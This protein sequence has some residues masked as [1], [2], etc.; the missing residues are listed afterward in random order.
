M[1]GQILH[2]STA[3]TGIAG[4]IEHEMWCPVCCRNNQP[5]RT[6]YT[7]SHCG[8]CGNYFSIDDPC[9]TVRA[10]REL[11][12]LSRREMGEKLKLK[13]RT[14]A[15]YENDWPSERYWKATRELVE[16]SDPDR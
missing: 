14:V 4:A 11:L 8:G 13:P 3:E 9:S 10:R 7:G 12:C 5:I 15:N 6:G 1:S 2:I 16:Q